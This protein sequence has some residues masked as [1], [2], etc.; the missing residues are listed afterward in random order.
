VI[1]QFLYESLLAPRFD[2][3]N[4]YIFKDVPLSLILNRAI[5][6]QGKEKIRPEFF[7]LALAGFNRHLRHE[8]VREMREGPS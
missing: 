6:L 7:G 8:A 2:G 4:F 1:E 3:K 5:Y